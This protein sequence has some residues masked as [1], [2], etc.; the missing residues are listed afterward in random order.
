MKDTHSPH[1]SDKLNAINALR[2]RGR[3]IFDIT[4]ARQ[5]SSGGRFFCLCYSL[6]FCGRRLKVYA[7]ATRRLQFCHAW[8]FHQIHTVC[9]YRRTSNANAPRMNSSLVRLILTSSQIRMPVY[10]RIK[11][12]CTSSSSEYSH[13]FSNCSVVKIEPVPF[14]I[15]IFIQFLCI[16]FIFVQ[17]ATKISQFFYF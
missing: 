2:I 5:T 15:R 12:S 10:V 14:P 17:V 3:K 11:I 9:L 7:Q 6:F 4:K 13:S 16:I 1:L 8:F